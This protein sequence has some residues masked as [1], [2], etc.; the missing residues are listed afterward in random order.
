MSGQASQA[1]QQPQQQPDLLFDNGRAL[2]ESIKADQVQE[3]A[4]FRKLKEYEMNAQINTLAYW[5]EN[6]GPQNRREISG[7]KL[8]LQSLKDMK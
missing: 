2:F 7:S 5:M 1:P 4:K 3:F 6:N 8:F